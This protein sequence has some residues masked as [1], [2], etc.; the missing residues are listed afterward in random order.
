MLQTYTYH[1]AN[2]FAESHFGGNPLA[3]FPNADGL[4]DEQMQ[5]IAQ[6]FNLSETVFLFAPT[7]PSAPSPQNLQEIVD[8]DETTGLHVL[9]K[10]RCVTSSVMEIV[11]SIF[12]S[13]ALRLSYTAIRSPG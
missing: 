6:Q 4:T 2:V 1:I 9:G 11:N 3:V 5:A 7:V 12:G 8:G 10:D 13:A